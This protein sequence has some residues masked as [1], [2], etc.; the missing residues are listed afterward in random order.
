MGYFDNF[1]KKK[2]TIGVDDNYKFNLHGCRVNKARLYTKDYV[3]VKVH[4]VELNIMQVKEMV[5]WFLNTL[6]AEKLML[7][8]AKLSWSLVQVWLGL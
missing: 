6:F 7:Q 3:K 1:V 2:L 5:S 4:S 8:Q